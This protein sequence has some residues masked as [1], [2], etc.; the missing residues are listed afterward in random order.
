M[1]GLDV[2]QEWIGEGQLIQYL[3][4]NR[5]EVEEGEAQD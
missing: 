3:R 5:R 4:L 2:Q 1:N